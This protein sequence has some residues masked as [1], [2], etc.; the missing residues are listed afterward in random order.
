MRACIGWAETG[1]PAWAAG[2]GQWTRHEPAW[3]AEGVAGQQ[4][5]PW[6]L[7]RQRVANRWQPGGATRKRRASGASTFPHPA[8]RTPHRH[9]RSCRCSRGTTHLPV[10]T[11]SPAVG[12]QSAARLRPPQLPAHRSSF[13][14]FPPQ[15]TSSPAYRW[16]P[17]LRAV[18]PWLRPAS[19]T[20]SLA[21]RTSLIQ[22]ALNVAWARHDAVAGEQQGA[23]QLN[24]PPGRGGPGWQARARLGSVRCPSCLLPA[25]LASRPQSGRPAFA[26]A[27]TASPA[28]GAYPPPHVAPLRLQT[29]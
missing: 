15:N 25:C 8:A 20:M 6:G 22:Q 2:G 10:N 23:G 26:L 21:Y 17:R 9:V 24:E 11:H 1:R 14:A 12:P 29:T 4:Q 7:S 5:A 27:C 19:R 16:V 13:P 28:A 3:Q 18:L